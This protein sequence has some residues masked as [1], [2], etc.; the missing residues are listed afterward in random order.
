MKFI[1]KV[2]IHPEVIIELNSKQRGYFLRPLKNYPSFIP[3]SKLL[4]S[5]HF[6]TCWSVG[7]E[8]LIK[9]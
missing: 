2:K 1:E 6:P 3:R 8:V 4:I 7:T 5:V 9:G